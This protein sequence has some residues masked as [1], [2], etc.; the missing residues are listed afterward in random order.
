M[1]RLMTVI[2]QTITGV[3]EVPLFTVRPHRGRAADRFLEVRVDRRFL[4]GVEPLQRNGA[5]AVHSLCSQLK[6]TE[7]NK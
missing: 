2:S 3:L 7:V 6:M 1:P 5:S 4:F